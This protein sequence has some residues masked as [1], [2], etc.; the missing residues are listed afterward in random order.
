[1]ADK[2]CGTSASGSISGFSWVYNSTSEK[3]SRSEAPLRFSYFPGLFESDYPTRP[4]VGNEQKCSSTLDFLPRKLVSIGPDH[5]ADIPVW[6]EPGTAVPSVAPLES[7]NLCQNAD[8]IDP[9][10]MMGTCVIPMPNLGS[11]VDEVGRGRTDCSCQDEGSLRCVRQHIIE[12]REKL[13]GK[14]GQKAFAELGFC[15][16]GEVIASKWTEEEEQD[17]SEVIAAHPASLG[18]NFWDQLCVVFPSRSKKEIVSYYFNVFMLRRRGEQNRLDPLNV[19]S[20]NDEWHCSEDGDEDDDSVVES[21]Q[22]EDQPLHRE[23]LNEE[24]ESGDDASCDNDMGDEVCAARFEYNRKPHYD[25][26]ACTGKSPG[27]FEDDHDLQDDSCTSYECQ[28]SRPDSYPVV[29]AE[30]QS[31]G[32]ESDHSKHFQNNY[33]GLNVMNNLGYGMETCDAKVW[34]VGF[35]SSYKTNVD[36]LPT[37]NMIEEVFGD[38]TWNNTGRDGNA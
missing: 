23:H 30:K 38:E 15:D 3:E 26:E 5:Q 9:E 10:R 14:F 4:Y 25:S 6:E 8:G 34:D 21:A 16:M 35:L 11:P 1:M 12:A 17:F 18:K 29:A 31:C 27:G 22:D 32:V 19:D 24:V 28:L 7:L 13:I 20:D 33:S 36:L 2:E 37:C